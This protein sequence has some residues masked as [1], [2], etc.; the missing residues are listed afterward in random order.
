MDIADLFE[1]YREDLSDAAQG[2]L[3]DIL[4]DMLVRR[5]GSRIKM[6]IRKKEKVVLDREDLTAMLEMRSGMTD[7]LTDIALIFAVL[8]LH[9]KEDYLTSRLGLILSVF[10]RVFTR[11]LNRMDALPDDGEKRDAYEVFHE[12]EVLY[13]ILSSFNKMAVGPDDDIAEGVTIH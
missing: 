8:S 11:G 13:K 1:K 6:S 2:E 5:F 4:N 3:D 9:D 7:L 12:L 10:M